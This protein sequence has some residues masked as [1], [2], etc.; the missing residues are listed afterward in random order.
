MCLMRRSQA[1][2]RGAREGTLSILVGGDKSDYTNCHELFEAMGTKYLITKVRQD[3]DSIANL[4]TR[5]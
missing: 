5:S 1:E 3:A 2:I 4:Q